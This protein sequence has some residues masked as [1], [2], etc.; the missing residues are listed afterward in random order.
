MKDI[1]IALGNSRQS[2]FWSNKTISFDNL[3]ERLKNPIRTTESASE[4]QK[5]PKPQRDSIKDKGGF[6]AGHLRDN[7]RKN[8]HVDCRSALVY[9]LDY[10]TPEFVADIKNKI[11][12]KGFVY[13]THSHTP[14]KPRVRAILPTERDMTPDEHNAVSRFI[15]QEIGILEMVDECSFE[16]NQLMYFPSCP[17]DGEYIFVELEGDPVDPDAVLAAHPNW[18]DCS[19][20]PTTPKESTAKKPAATKQKNPLDK[21]G[22]VGLFC[23]LYTVEDAIDKFLSGVYEPVANTPGRYTYIAGESTAGLV[24]YE[25]GTFAYSHH[26]T[27]PAFGKLLNAFDL[28]RVHKFPDAEPKQSY[29]DMADFVMGLPEI[30]VLAA[31]ERMAKAGDDFTD[32]SGDEDA[33]AWLAGLDYDK[34]GVLLNSLH[35]IRLIMENDPELKG[36]VFNQLADG[37]EIKGEVPWKHP[38]RFW[39]DA[40]D[41]QLISYIDEKYGSF[42]QRNYQIGV[43]KVSDDRS[44]HPIREYFESLPEW[45]KEKRAE[46][47]FIDYLGA[48]D[49]AY[50]RAATRKSLCAAY[51]RIYAPG[52]KFD[53]SVVLNGP[54][55]IGKS[56]VIAKL[57]MQWYSDSLSL[58]DMNDKTAA[59]KLQGFWMLEIGELA[60]MKKADIDKVKAFI[61]RQDDKYRA[62]FGRRVTPH[63][64]QCVFIGTTNSETGYL[65]DITGNRRFWNIKVTGDSAKHPWDMTQE[66]VDQIWAEVKEI[67]DDENLYLPPELEDYAKQEQNEAME[68]DEREGLVAEYLDTLLPESWG[69]MDF[70]DRKNYIR[71]K[72]DPTQPEGTVLRETVSNMEIWCECLGRQKEELRPSDSYLITAIMM[73]MPGWERTDERPRLKFYGQQRIYRRKHGR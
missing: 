58:S 5:L 4:Y 59:E 44:Y 8:D 49:N 64:R 18:M 30:K 9:D 27:D 48:E 42:S 52:I 61:S 10:A 40:D 54:Q 36:I 50:V 70:Y 34:N 31:K 33:D 19:L 14:D 32:D 51:R 21:E 63:P 20:L 53:H 16:A 15:A 28:V 41:A 25:N 3:R 11:P 38:A 69:E 26:A 66:L 37:M 23:R 72:E 67:A 22:A 71:D 45:D 73:R 47:I 24:L 68:Q 35:N 2:K 62:S 60:G 6:V 57:G 17:S 46:S 39:R 7:C 1:K 12:H 29:K 65:R 55:G 43:T 56:T 13:S